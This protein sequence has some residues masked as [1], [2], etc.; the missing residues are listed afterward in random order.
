MQEKKLW[1]HLK[2]GNVGRFWTD[3]KEKN[4]S[5]ILDVNQTTLNNLKRSS[6]KILQ[7]EILH[8]ESI[9]CYSFSTS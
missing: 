1:K 3:E 2:F 6:R 8:F 7:E 9:T 4:I 5:T